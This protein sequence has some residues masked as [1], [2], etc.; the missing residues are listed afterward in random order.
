MSGEL[1]VLAALCLLSA[2][3]QFV[4]HRSQDPGRASEP[5]PLSTKL[6]LL[7]GL[8]LG[9]VAVANMLRG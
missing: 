4:R 2:G 7:A 3:A 9:A 5:Y 8:L 1:W 6:M